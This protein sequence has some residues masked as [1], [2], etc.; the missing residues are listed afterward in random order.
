[1]WPDRVSNP[2]PLYVRIIKYWCKVLNTDIIIIQKLYKA[3]EILRS[4]RLNG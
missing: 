2:G 3:L 4:E 1:M